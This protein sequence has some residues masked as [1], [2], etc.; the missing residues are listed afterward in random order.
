[1]FSDI[2]SFPRGS[3]LRAWNLSDEQM[4]WGPIFKLPQHQNR[5]YMVWFVLANYP[6]D[7]KI[8]LL[9]YHLF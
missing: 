9:L 6:L 4:I 3:I 2:D 8:D 1:M 5:R 7:N